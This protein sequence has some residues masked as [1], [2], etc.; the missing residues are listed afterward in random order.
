[1]S[2]DYTASL[3]VGFVFSYHD[4]DKFK[5]K[6][7]PVYRDEPRFNPKTGK[8]TKP[9]RVCVE[10]GGECWQLGTRPEFESVDDLMM[11]VS[12]VVGAALYR[13]GSYYD[14]EENTSWILCPDLDPVLDT[15]LQI[16]DGSFDVGGSIK[17][18]DLPKLD[19]ELTH[20]GN[21]LKKLGLPVR[22]PV[23]MV[24]GMIS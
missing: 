11:A 15:S 8:P 6:S 17:L 16:E 5:V 3:L 14:D 13:H 10:P 23:V 12:D 9:E 20:I 22:D 21:E 4:L 7:E 18:R 19:L 2:I 24:A 1:M